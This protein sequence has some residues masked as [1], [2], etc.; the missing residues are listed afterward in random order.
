MAETWSLID[1]ETRREPDMIGCEAAL[2]EGERVEE[3]GLGRGMGS[4]RLRR[5]GVSLNGA[6]RLQ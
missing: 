5:M 1:T 2:R 6:S 3:E 4:G